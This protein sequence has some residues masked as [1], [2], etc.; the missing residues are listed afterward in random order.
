MLLQPTPCPPISML[1][2]A[3][4][5]KPSSKQKGPLTSEKPIRLDNTEIRRGAGRP[6]IQPD[7]HYNVRPS[8]LKHCP[9]VIQSVQAPSANIS[10]TRQRWPISI[11][12][13]WNQ[14]RMGPSRIW[15][16]WLGKCRNDWITT[17]N[18]NITYLGLEAQSPRAL[19]IKKGLHWQMQ[20]PQP[21]N[22]LNLAYWMHSKSIPNPIPNPIQKPVPKL[23]KREKTLLNPCR[24]RHDSSDGQEIL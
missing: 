18:P 7:L 24:A 16:W 13:T 6:V 20:F 9:I 3:A 22:H 10:K 19:R 12:W 5:K 1:L 11:F 4:A 23:Q 15:K 2:E 8:L 14:W 17:S 21:V